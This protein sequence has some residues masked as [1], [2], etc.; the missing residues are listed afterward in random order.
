M[1]IFEQM[2]M[3]SLKAAA[4]QTQEEDTRMAQPATTTSMIDT[5]QSSHNTTSTTVTAK[6]SKERSLQEYYEDCKFDEGV[7]SFT[8]F[9]QSQFTKH[10][11]FIVPSGFV[12]SEESFHFYNRGRELWKSQGDMRDDLEDLFRHQLEKSDLLQGF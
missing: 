1:S 7:S 5:T 10:N 12:G 6:Q 9:M 8:D 11:M 4:P 3:Q 2:Y